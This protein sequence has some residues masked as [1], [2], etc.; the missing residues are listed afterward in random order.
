MQRIISG[1]ALQLG[2]MSAMTGL[3]LVGGLGA[4]SGCATFAPASTQTLLA[5]IIEMNG[6]VQDLGSES[7]PD[8]V[9]AR[10]SEIEAEARAIGAASTAASQA[11]AIGQQDRERIGML[12]ESDPRRSIRQTA[13]DVMGM[14][15]SIDLINERLEYLVLD[16]R[17][18]EELAQ[19]GLRRSVGMIGQ[20]AASFV[21]GPFAPVINIAALGL[22]ALFAEAFDDTSERIERYTDQREMN[23]IFLVQQAELLARITPDE[24][25]QTTA[26]VNTLSED[27][28]RAYYAELARLESEDLANLGQGRAPPIEV[29]PTTPEE[30]AALAV[31]N[32]ARASELQR[33]M[34]DDLAGF[35]V[36]PTDEQMDE[37]LMG[38]DRSGPNVA[39]ARATLERQAMADAFIR[40]RQYLNEIYADVWW[41]SRFFE[42]QM[43]ALAAVRDRPTMVARDDPQRPGETVMIPAT[44]AL[45]QDER[46]MVALHGEMTAIHDQ[47]VGAAACLGVQ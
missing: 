8:D 27:A 34:R 42:R 26:F 15:Q 5:E 6:E 12:V 24:S 9:L 32:A 17:P 35:Y 22:G 3:L 25:R 13:G 18:A 4:L 7:V 47:Y 2:R 10:A 16:G 36:A 44:S 40:T 41:T 43:E 39:M 14:L 28:R 37:A 29:M 33:N 30:A 11:N 23:T 1:N 20:L 38:M 21:G 45:V 19:E 46:R 31:R